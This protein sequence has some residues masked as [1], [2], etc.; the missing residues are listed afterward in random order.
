MRTIGYILLS[1]GLI[2]IVLDQGAV[3]AIGKA[4]N[5]EYSQKVPKRPCYQLDE[6]QKVISEIL[7]L[8]AERIPPFYIGAILMFIGGV[9]ID[10]AGRRQRRCHR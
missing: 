4:T 1:L 2:W 8:Y 9:M 3:Y 6:V 10:V 5:Y 7:V